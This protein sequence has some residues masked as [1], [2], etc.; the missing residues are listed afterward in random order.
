[1]LF[2]SGAEDDSVG[3]FSSKS[4]PMALN[5]ALIMEYRNDKRVTLHKKRQKGRSIA[6]RVEREGGLG[7]RNLYSIKEKKRREM[8]HINTFGRSILSCTR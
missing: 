5:N 8:K 4:R 2:R 1:M 6:E 3:E 7:K